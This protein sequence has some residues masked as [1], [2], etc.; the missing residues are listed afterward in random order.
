MQAEVLLILIFHC[1]LGLFFFARKKKNLF[2]KQ[3]RPFPV[4]YEQVVI[5]NF[6]II[7]QR[8]PIQYG[9]FTVWFEW[10]V[11]SHSKTKIVLESW[12]LLWVSTAHAYDQPVNSIRGKRVFA[13][14]VENEV[15][16]QVLKLKRKPTKK[17][18]VIESSLLKARICQPIKTAEIS[19]VA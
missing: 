9:A 11:S 15:V 17:R 6:G 2:Q 13:R 3:S 18:N 7:N 4:E 14:D 8:N 1:C 10:Q 5:S 16:K 12:L 19:H